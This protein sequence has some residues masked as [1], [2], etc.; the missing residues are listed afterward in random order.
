MIDYIKGELVELGPTEAVIEAGG[1][2][3]SILISLQSFSALQENK[4]AA[5]LYIH[6]YLREDEELYYGFATKDERTLFR[7]LISVSGIGANT[8]RMMLSSMTSDEI[9]DS[10][11]A[12]DVNKIKSIKGIG[13]KTAQRLI[14]EL[15]DK[16]VKGGASDASILDT[17][18]GAEIME[19]A[20]TA[21][22]MLGFT[23]ANVNKALEAINKEHPGASI[24]E[25][26][27]FAL[28]RL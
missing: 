18:P 21:L 12:S 27:K 24:E 23:K 10:I 3:Y 20:T 2:G 5:T 9:R 22:V 6:H 26:I 11:I 1:I 16:I 15:K 8:A 13:L 17:R 28:K 14:L 7:L 25:L 19:E 4:G